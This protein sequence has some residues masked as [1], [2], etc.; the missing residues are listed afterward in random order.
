MTPQANFMVLAAIDPPREAELRGLLALMNDA[1]GRVNADNALIPF[2]QFDTLHFAR[3][4]ILNDKTIEDARAYGIPT[5]TYPLY[6][7]FLGDIDGDVESFFKELVKRAEKG[8]RSIF[9]CCAGFTSDTDLVGWMK[10]HSAPAIANYVNWRGRTVRRIREEAALKDTLEEYLQVHA[11]T[12]TGIPPRE[13]VSKLQQFV[14]AE[15]STGR[16]T[17]S[18]ESLTPIGWWIKNALHLIGVPLL[19]LIALP[20]LIVIAPIFLIRLRHLEKGDAELCWRV[21]QAHS[22]ALA[23]FED[24]LVTNQFTAMGSLKPGIVRLLT[25]IGI[26][27]TV[28]YAARHFVRRGRLGRIRTIHFARWVFLDGRK[29][30][31]FFSNYDGTVESYMDDFINKTG[32]GLNAVFSNG[33]GY[34]RTNWLVRDGCGDEQKYKNFLRRHTL[35]TQVWYKA[36]PGLTAIDLERNRLIREGLESSSMSEQE[37]REWVALL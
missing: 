21:D 34:P 28:D 16:L 13:I 27:S 15:K 14:N 3:F 29:R 2:A 24:H 26:L 37:A 6:L 4:V 11:P 8:L 17:L 32:F 5:R 30:M 9:S 18:D 35:P 1:P 20:L 22:D 23:H 7:A 36:Y 31:V 25:L 19:F 10:Q 12:L 33:I